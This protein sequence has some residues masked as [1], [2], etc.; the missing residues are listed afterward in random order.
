MDRVLI[1]N[2]VHIPLNAPKEPIVFQIGFYRNSIFNPLYLGR[3]MGPNTTIRSR[4]TNH[5]SDNGNKEIKE[6]FD[7]TKTN[8][9]YFRWM[10]TKDL[11]RIEAILLK[12]F[13]IGEDRLNKWSKHKKARSKL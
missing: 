1:S 8:Y 4:L 5:F 11:K 10:V 13:G 2:I 12:R 3:A 9:L 7:E 6:Y